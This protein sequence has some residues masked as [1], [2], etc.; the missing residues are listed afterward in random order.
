MGPTLSIGNGLRDDLLSFSGSG[1]PY[2][3]PEECW[4]W[5]PFEAAGEYV[6][7]RYCFSAYFYVYAL[8]L[9]T[10]SGRIVSA[11][12]QPLQSPSDARGS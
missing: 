11:P 3:L 7:L 10:F 4:F 12:N 1:S 9:G 6:K 2:R 5:R 8:R